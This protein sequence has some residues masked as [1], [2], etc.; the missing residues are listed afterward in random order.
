MYKITVYLYIYIYIYIYIYMHIYIVYIIFWM[1]TWL[2][3]KVKA[4]PLNDKKH[5]HEANFC[6]WPMGI[7]VE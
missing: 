3:L 7:A 4:I 2:T 5:D 6:N 1:M